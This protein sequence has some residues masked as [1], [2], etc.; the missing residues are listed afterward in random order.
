[1]TG[2]RRTGLVAVICALTAQTAVAQANSRDAQ[3]AREI[4]ALFDQ[5]NA[6]W[7][8]RDPA[9]IERFYVHDP[10]ALFFFE[11][12]QLT[13]W[14]SIRTLYDAMFASAKR[15]TIRSSYNNLSLH[16]RGDVGWLAVNFRLEI[17]EPDGTSS[18]DEGRES[19]VFER[20]AGS[21]VVVHRHTSFQAPAGPQ[22]HVPL[23]TG[24]GPL[25]S[26]APAE[27]PADERAIRLSREGSNR[28]IASHDTAGIAAAMATDV[29]VV[30]STGAVITG[31]VA[32]AAAFAA[33]F[34]SRPDLV[35][36]R[37]PD[38]VRVYAPWGMA[39]EYGTWRGTWTQTN[40][41]STEQVEV[42]GRYFAKWRKDGD[43]WAIHAEVY[44]PLYC[45]GRSY[46]QR[47]R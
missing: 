24:T 11:R 42:G 20:R 10:D 16:A 40:Q 17:T 38:S 13:G 46:C 31:R 14:D 21:W 15:G 28:A 45:R 5:F 32:N 35:Y 7:E 34:A 4:R 36:R 6:A 43:P 26:D 8:R 3:S 18:V 29:T 37:T 22:R 44:L 39:G 19:M 1:M 33:Q 23:A 30:T 27:S 12:R 25:W 9:F 47:G 2:T 41:G